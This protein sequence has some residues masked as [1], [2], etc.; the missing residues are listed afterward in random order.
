MRKVLGIIG[1]ATAM[2][3][4]TVLY[5]V[6]AIAQTTSRAESDR[7][8]FVAYCAS[9][10]GRDGRGN[11]PV[12]DGFRVRPQDLTQFA[13]RNGGAF[14]AEA[15]RRIIDG[16]DVRVRSHGASGMPVWG[17]A[18]VKREGLDERAARARIEAIVRY[19]ESI[20]ERSGH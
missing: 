18:F 10:H 15:T 19:L 11:G 6:T 3:A 12:A 20:Q 9:C 14:P 7:M 13:R 17:D 8:L 1:A 16:R 5:S 4:G 2:L